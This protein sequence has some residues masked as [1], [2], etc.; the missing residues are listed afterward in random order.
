MDR[1]LGRHKEIT[2][3]Q[4]DIS[5]MQVSFDNEAL[6][7]GLVRVWRIDRSGLHP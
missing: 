5:K 6:L 7:V 1:T 2:G 3:T 4:L